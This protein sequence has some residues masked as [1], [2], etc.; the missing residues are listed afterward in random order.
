MGTDL[1]DAQWGLIRPL[2]PPAKATGRPRANDRRTLNGILYL[3]RTGCRWK[4]L[5]ERYPSR[6]TCHRRFQWLV[7]SGALES[8]LWA[9]AQDLKERG[10]LD[11]SECFIDGTFVPAKKGALGSGR[12]SG[13][14]AARSW[15]WQTVLVFLSPY[16][17][18]VLARMKSRS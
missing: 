11:L 16:A 17:Q 4:D 10:G 6:A 1:S 7:R 9:L 2:L 13:A 18:P 5:P 14:K 15:Q 3:L 8:I 12:P